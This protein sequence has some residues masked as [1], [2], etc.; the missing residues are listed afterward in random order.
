MDNRGHRALPA[1]AGQSGGASDPDRR[2]NT[3]LLVPALPGDRYAQGLRRHPPV[4]GTRRSVVARPH[5]VIGLCQ[6][7][8]PAPAIHGRTPLLMSMHAVA[9]PEV[10]VTIG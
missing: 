2:A 6:V 8:G 3:R 1:G 9:L 5:L 7:D 4:R 10:G